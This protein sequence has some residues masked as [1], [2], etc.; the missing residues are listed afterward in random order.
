[1]NEAMLPTGSDRNK[2]EY[3][4]TLL[5]EGCEC[6][7]GNT[8]SDMDGVNLL[9]NPNFSAGESL[10]DVLSPFWWFTLTPTTFT[11]NAKL[12][13]YYQNKFD[14]DCLGQSERFFA[15]SHWGM[16]M[17]TTSENATAAVGTVRA[18][19]NPTNELKN[20]AP[21]G[22]NQSSEA[23][24][25]FSLFTTPATQAETDLYSLHAAFADEV[26]SDSRVMMVGIKWGIAELDENNR[27]SNVIVECGFGE[28]T[29][30]Y[31][32]M[33]RSEYTLDNIELKRNTEYVVYYRSA[34]HVLTQYGLSGL[35]VYKNSQ[36]KPLTPS[37]A[38]ASGIGNGISMTY[39]GEKTDDAGQWFTYEPKFKA[40]YPIKDRII[41]VITSDYL[42]EGTKF[43]F[44]GHLSTNADFSSSA[45][46]NTQVDVLTQHIKVTDGNLT[47]YK[48]LSEL[49][50]IHVLMFESS[51]PLKIGFWDFL[52]TRTGYDYDENPTSTWRLLPASDHYI[53]WLVADV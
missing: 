11:K 38:P 53:D 25:H 4:L 28:T 8:Q 5:G 20:R 9:K 35:A 34:G 2:I 27:V 31:E 39:L 36:A 40:P 33:P 50:G 26:A 22:G 48:G 37:F 32:L 41:T 45:Y 29:G 10:A 46:L 12:S 3:L 47:M 43:D 18:L 13:A 6:D 21:V 15:P 49:H 52:K 30:P 7:A 17:T 16:E 24:V 23:G 42:K 19:D 14:N 44:V 1:M 51:H